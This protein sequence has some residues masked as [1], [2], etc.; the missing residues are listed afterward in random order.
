M[1]LAII[2]ALVAI[3][4]LLLLVDLFRPRHRTPGAFAGPPSGKERPVPMATAKA[5]AAAPERVPAPVPAALVAPSAP[6][7][8]AGVALGA[9]A[10]HSPVRSPIGGSGT[11][12]A[13]A[14]LSPEASIRLPVP[15]VEPR[16]SAPSTLLAG[17][18]A[19]AGVIA[20]PA[21]PAHRATIE[22]ARAVAEAAARI[23]VTPRTPKAGAA[24]PEVITAAPPFEESSE[25]E[26]IRGRRHGIRAK[27]GPFAPTGGRRDFFGDGLLAGTVAER[28]DAA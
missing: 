26:V 4:L 13:L 1:A 7:P 18:P 16:P 23:P 5:A 22:A 14:G 15:H 3:P 8:A 19:T 28:S 12:D 20:P 21:L 2:A 6:V 25:I 9:V 24:A 27:K 11:S 10:S 17:V